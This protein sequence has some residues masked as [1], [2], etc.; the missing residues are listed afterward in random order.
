MTTEWSVETLE[1]TNDAN[2]IVA[3]V[4]WRC[5][6][7]EDQNGEIY[8]TDYIGVS[9]VDEITADAEGFI[10]YTE[11]TESTTLGWAWAKIDKDQIEDRVKQTIAEQT[12]P[13][14]KSGRP[15]E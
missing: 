9:E 14:L 11:L 2:K 6:A 8:A 15:W 4:H 7:R 5:H 3:R 12:T 13:A 10:P 1:Y